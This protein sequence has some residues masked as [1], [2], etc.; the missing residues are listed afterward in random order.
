MVRWELL[1]RFRWVRD[2]ETFLIG[3]E[4]CDVRD[5]GWE[6]VERRFGAPVVYWRVE[7]KASW[8]IFATI[9]TQIILEIFCEPKA[10]DRYRRFSVRFSSRLPV[11]QHKITD[12]IDWPIS[13]YVN[14][15]SSEVSRLLSHALKCT[16]ACAKN[17]ELKKARDFQ[18]DY[19][20]ANMSLAKIAL[21]ER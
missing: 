21:S 6:M 18:S 8:P 16:S 1:W 20:T 17:L 13:T 7:R 10:T 15:F 9:S 14:Q 19:R 3:T 4:M 12:L 2:W 11:M 5:K